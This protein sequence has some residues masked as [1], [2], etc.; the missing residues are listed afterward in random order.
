MYIAIDFD[1]TVVSSAFPSVGSELPHAVDVMKRL[2][3]YGNELILLTNRENVI[4]ED[5][6]G[7]HDILAEA[8]NWFKERGIDLYAVNDNPKSKLNYHIG[9]KVFADVYIDDHGLGIPKYY[10]GTLN[11]YGIEKLLE[12]EGC[13]TRQLILGI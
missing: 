8:V 3:K 12:N 1:G 11:W 4:Y 10:D 13:F 2:L 9:R 5:E 6:N 7:S